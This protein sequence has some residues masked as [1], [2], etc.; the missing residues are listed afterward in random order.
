VTDVIPYRLDLASRMGATLAVDAGRADMKGVQKSLGMKEGFD[1]GLE[2]SGT[3][4]GL[5]TILEN[6][7]SGA[8]IALLGILSR[9]TS[10]DWARMVFKGLTLKGIYGRRMFET[11]HKMNVMVQMGLDISPVITHRFHYTEFEKGFEVMNSG[12]SGKVVLDWMEN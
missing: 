2:M 9:E 8:N 7:R 6:V 12:L 3:P 11:W 10:I 5:R 1:V 4:G